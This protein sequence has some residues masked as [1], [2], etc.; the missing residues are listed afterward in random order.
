[1][2]FFLLTAIY[3]QSSSKCVCAYGPGAMYQQQESENRPYF[4]PLKSLSSEGGSKE[5]RNFPLRIHMNDP[6]VN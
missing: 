6:K 2:G 4:E 3:I 5:M 1:M